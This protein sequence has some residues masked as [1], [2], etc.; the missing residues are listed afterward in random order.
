MQLWSRDKPYRRMIC[1]K[2]NL[3]LASDSIEPQREWTFPPVG[4]E[5]LTMRTDGSRQH[6]YNKTF[7]R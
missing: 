5:S 4:A 1:I 7:P 6:A 3:H 2:R